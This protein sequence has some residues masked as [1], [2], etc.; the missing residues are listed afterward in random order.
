M[1][2][3]GTTI[4][5]TSAAI[6]LANSAG[7]TSLNDSTPR[8]TSSEKSAPPNGTPY[9]A[10]IPAPA[11]HATNNRRCSSDNPAPVEN[12]FPN[13]A[14]A[15]LGAPSR[16]SDTPMPTRKIESIA[17]PKVRSGGNRPAEN[18]MAALIS[19][20]LP[21]DR[22]DRSN[23]PKPVR[24]PAPSRMRRCRANDA[25]A[26]ASYHDDPAPGHATR[27]THCSSR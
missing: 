9:A 22:P 5:A 8:S 27:C 18:Q 11:P 3:L 15:C 12:R 4:Q 14:P 13:T 26:A 20:P 6:V 17:L 16:P 2:P 21:L 1:G 23:C 25:L 19:I 7:R 10:D 24:K